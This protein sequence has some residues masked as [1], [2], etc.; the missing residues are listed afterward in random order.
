M[1]FLRL[2]TSN[3]GTIQKSETLDER[4][5]PNSSKRKE[6]KNV[7]LIQ[8]NENRVHEKES[9][10]ED[11]GHL[12]KRNVQIRDRLKRMSLRAAVIFA[13]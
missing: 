3:A 11:H 12:L 13:R 6:K 4:E 10:E 5:I 2:V 8:I 1:F 9:P 7:I